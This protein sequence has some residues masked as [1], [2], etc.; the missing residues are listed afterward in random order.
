[1]RSRYRFTSS[2][3]IHASLRLAG[4]RSWTLLVGRSSLIMWGHLRIACALTTVGSFLK[5]TKESVIQ[6]NT[7]GKPICCRVRYLFI[8]SDPISIHQC[9]W[10]SACYCDRPLLCN[11]QY[12]LPLLISASSPPPPPTHHPIHS[13]KPPLAF[14]FPSPYHS[15]P[16]IHSH[17]HI[18]RP[19]YERKDKRSNISSW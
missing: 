12:H 1:M 5:G 2:W 4:M 13:S 10:Y 3:V 8:F 14:P 18:L 15:V 9:Q 6:Q 17:H 11:Y 7:Y 19:I 16:D